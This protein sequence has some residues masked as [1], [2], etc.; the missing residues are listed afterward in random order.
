VIQLPAKTQW[1]FG[2]PHFA[3][4]NPCDHQITYKGGQLA[5]EEQQI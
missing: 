2:A 3:T 1:H 5:D 4:I